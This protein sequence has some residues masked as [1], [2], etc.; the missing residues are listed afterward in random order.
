MSDSLR[1]HGLQHTRP[2]CPSPAPG[3]YSDSCP[4][5]RWCHPTI[6]SS[7]N[8]KHLEGYPDGSDGKES[9]CNV[10]ELGSIP[11][12]GRSLEKGRATHPSILA[13]K[14]PQ[15]E[16][17]G[18]LQ[19]MGSR[20]VRL[21]W[22]ANTFTFRRLQ[23]ILKGILMIAEFRAKLEKSPTKVAAQWTFSV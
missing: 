10:G 22:G 23:G 5:S 20:R 1:P 15:T 19:S 3:V 17:P 14:I 4:L 18:G 8:F 12:L 6:S 7:V 2:P 11:E 16:E 21:S 9:A 13:W